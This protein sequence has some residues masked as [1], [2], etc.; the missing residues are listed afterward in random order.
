MLPNNVAYPAKLN[1]PAELQAEMM[2]VVRLEEILPRP[3]AGLLHR[4]LRLAPI[5]LV[6][7]PATSEPVL[8]LRPNAHYQVSVRIYQVRDRCRLPDLAMMT[9]AGLASTMLPA[10]IYHGAGMSYRS[11]D[12]PADC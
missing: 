12:Y 1:K 10:I 6:L 4:M 7:H 5:D 2:L 8:V 11:S 9:V 3:G